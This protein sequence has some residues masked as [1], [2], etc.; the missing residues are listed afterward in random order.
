MT[1]KERRA[2]KKER[3]EKEENWPVTVETA[4]QQCREIIADLKDWAD[5]KM[6]FDHDA[7]SRIDEAHFQICVMLNP[8]W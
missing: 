2:V 5:G 4:K 3:R 6:V 1:R 8:K 7:I